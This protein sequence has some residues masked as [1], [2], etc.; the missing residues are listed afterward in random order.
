[1]S[2]CLPFSHSINYFQCTIFLYPVLYLLSPLAT[3]LDC[4]AASCP[5]INQILINQLIEAEGIFML[6]PIT[7]QSVSTRAA[8]L[9]MDGEEMFTSMDEAQ[10]NRRP[11]YV[12]AITLRIGFVA[13]L[14]LKAFAIWQW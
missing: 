2:S 9:F 1:L 5:I 4:D 13:A 3:I 10:S 8:T 12:L 14:L 6:R 7:P 11:F